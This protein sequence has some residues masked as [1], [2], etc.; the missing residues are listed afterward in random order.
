MFKAGID[1]VPEGI[2][3]LVNLQYLDLRCP[4][5]VELPTQIL[6][7]LSHLQYLTV[8]PKS[9][10]LKIKGE[11]VSGLK[12]LE[13][14]Q[15]QLYDLQDL[16]NYVKSNHFKRLSNYQLVVGQVEDAFDPSTN[17]SKAIS[18]GECEIGGEDS[19]VLPDDVED[20]WINRC[21]KFRSLSDIYS[22][23]KT[24]ELRSCFVT[25]CEEIECVVDMVTSSSSFINNLEWLWLNKL[26]NLS[27]VVNVGGAEATSPHIF[28]NLK[29]FGMWE[30][31]RM[32]RLFS[33]ELLQGLQNLEDIELRIVNKW[34]K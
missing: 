33:L 5:L 15:A 26:P 25:K 11:E 6:S 18:L 31:S 19:V 14:F 16:N 21:R 12:K 34:R 4:E 17:L 23:Q 28:S 13:T 7:N 9:I 27:V 22:L 24:T 29:S 30:C 8:Y 3:M 10:T 20:L 32:K 1:V 2:D